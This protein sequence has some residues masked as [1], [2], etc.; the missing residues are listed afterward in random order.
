M[1]T[2]PSFWKVAKGYME[3]KYQKVR[4]VS[5][6]IA[7]SS[8][9]LCMTPDHTVSALLAEEH[10]VDGSLSALA[11]SVP[12]HDAGHCH[13]LRLAPLSVLHPFLVDLATCHYEDGV[14]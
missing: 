10:F 9:G 11:N 3:G 7:Y 13:P 5:L 6:R 8:Q 12:R 2:L 14:R 1:Q 4:S